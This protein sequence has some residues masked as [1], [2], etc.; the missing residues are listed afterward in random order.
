MAPSADKRAPARL[1][2]A[3]FLFSLVVLGAA[4][5]Q[6]LPRY[7]AHWLSWY[8]LP[9]ECFLHGLDVIDPGGRGWAWSRMPM[10]SVPRALLFEHWG[11]S[12]SWCLLPAYVELGL[13]LALSSL[14]GLAVAPWGAAAA[15]L[16]LPLSRGNVYANPMDPLSSLLVLLLAGLLVWRERRATPGRTL[17]VALAVG[18]SLLYRSVL[19]L[20][21]PLLIA[22][23]WRALRGRRQQLMLL[24]LV[25][26]LF[27]LPWIRMNWVV[28]HRVI[29]FEDR[30]PDFNMMSAA[31]GVDDAL[32]IVSEPYEVMDEPPREGQSMKRWALAQIARHPLRYLAGFGRRLARVAGWHLWLI[33]PA[34]AAVWLNR[35]K[36]EYLLVALLASYLLVVYCTMSIVERYFAPVWPLAAVLSAAALRAATARGRP[37]SESL[38]SRRAAAAML[39]STLALVLAGAAYTIHVVDRFAALAR[40]RSP[41]STQA[42]EAALPDC[43]HPAWLWSTLG[44]R[45]LRDGDVG[46]ALDAFRRARL[47]PGPVDPRFEA[48]VAWA[49]ALVGKE[50]PLLRGPTEEPGRGGFARHVYAAHILAKSR[51]G[52]AARRAL[53]E[54]LDVYNTRLVIHGPRTP[55][56]ELLFKRLRT[57]DNGFASAAYHVIE[58]RPLEER[59]AFLAELLG[60]LPRSSRAWLLLARVEAERKRFQDALDDAVYAESLEPGMQDRLMLGRLAYLRGLGLTPKKPARAGQPADPAILTWALDHG[61]P[62]NYRLP[63]DGPLARWLSAGR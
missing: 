62:G 31:I 16:L 30:A 33:L 60:V 44:A 17:L 49:R 45:R 22:F 39:L 35:R 54:A 29:L 55:Q 4:G 53:R 6:L 13:V 32:E 38:W 40:S 34:V 59:V 2:A 12:R 46:A 52:A 23:D 47:E 27:L 28:H 61:V 7:Y 51:R 14:L 36:R 11:L 15:A 41:S 1:R 50:G 9:G 48:I 63:A 8:D 3:A 37:A 18:S 43:P 26:Y 57:Y 5:W 10:L 58:F 56:K 20:F 25:P 42:L 21:P 19:V 24:G